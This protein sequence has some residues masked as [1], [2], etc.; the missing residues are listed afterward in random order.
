MHLGQRIE[1]REVV[2]RTSLTPD[3]CIE[4]LRLGSGL[5][6]AFE[7]LRLEL[8]DE[9]VVDQALLI[10]LDGGRS[11]RLKVGRA[12]VYT[13]DLVDAQVEGVSKTP[14]RCVVGRWLV[15]QGRSLCSQ[16]VEQ[17][18][19]G[20]APARPP[21]EAPEIGQIPNA[22]A[23]ARPQRAEL[24][25]PAPSALGRGDGRAGREL[26]T[27]HARRLVV[28][29]AHGGEDGV[30]SRARGRNQVTL[31]AVVGGQDPPAPGTVTHVPA[32]LPFA[33]MTRGTAG[34][35][36]HVPAEACTPPTAP[37]PGVALT[38]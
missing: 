22:P 24:D 9:V 38:A 21:A 4:T 12:S 8:E 34:Q 28:G 6:Y 17:D 30:G 25:G 3:P 27:P 20:A 32:K 31:P 2:Q 7:R 23:V 29:G 26:E 11:Q 15:G 1:G 16:R 14:R 33:P 19:R 10:E 36:H 13:F 37:T 5:K 18:H 35:L